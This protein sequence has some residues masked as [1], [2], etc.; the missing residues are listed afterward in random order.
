MPK[1]TRHIVSGILADSP[2]GYVLRVDGGGAW[3]LEPK[4]SLRNWLRRH[5]TVEG[6]RTGFDF[7]TVERIE[8]SGTA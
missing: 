8:P 4:R 2:R 1:G 3:T 5:V 7:L 6:V